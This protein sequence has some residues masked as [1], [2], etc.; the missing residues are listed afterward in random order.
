MAGFGFSDKPVSDLT[1]KKITINDLS[2][3]NQWFDQYNHNVINCY[4]LLAEV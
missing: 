1:I 2:I 3:Y 4:W